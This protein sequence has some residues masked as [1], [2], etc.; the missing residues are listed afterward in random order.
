MKVAIIGL[1]TEGKKSIYSFIEYGW[2]VYAS[3]LNKKIDVADIIKN[4]PLD[5]SK[6]LDIDLGF[7]DFKKIKDADA[8]ALSPSL[9]KT[10]LAKDA[11]KSKKL[12]SDI[13]L[14][15]KDIFTIAITGTNGKTT[16]SHMLFKILKNHGLNVLMGGN[17][18]GGF[19]GYN[20][21]ILESEYYNGKYDVIIVEVCDMTLDLTDYYFNFDLVILT[22]M[23]ND[24]MDHHGSFDNYEKSLFKFLKNK[25]IV[26][27]EDNIQF[28]DVALSYEIFKPT[29]IKL[30]LVGA[31][32][33]LNAGAAECSALKLNIPYGII[34]DTLTNFK[35]VDGR[36]TVFNLKTS[37]NNVLNNEN[38]LYIGKTDNIDALNA[39]LDEENFNTIFIG[40]PR[41]NE[42]C[43]WEILDS[44][45]EKNIKNLVIY[46]GLDDT[47]EMASEHI[48]NSKYDGNLIIAK[49]YSDLFKLIEAYK[50]YGNILVA[51]NG[52]NT[53]TKLQK[54]LRDIYNELS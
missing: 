44:L 42:S 22:N 34:E 33:K 32:N 24:H 3:D 12:I 39:V 38:L 17:A 9:W 14:K 40:T 23:G 31:F 15:H 20:K 54:D 29:D 1:G 16:T 19:D 8:V 49:D 25:N 41:A 21:L 28:K 50:Q 5:Y 46:R 45:I 43:R 13:L 37:Q 36:M 18:G 2:D 47:V 53:I 48:K 26:I 4:I 27:N 11:I 7:H 52:Q 35:T 10:Q 30:K 6:K 51:G